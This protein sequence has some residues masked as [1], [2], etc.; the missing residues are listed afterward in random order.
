M[1]F[2][3]GIMTEIKVTSGKQD[4]YLNRKYKDVDLIFY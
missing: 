1:A 3:T 4:E 2:L